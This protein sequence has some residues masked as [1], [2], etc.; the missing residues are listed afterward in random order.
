MFLIGLLISDS[1][2]QDEFD[3]IPNKET[4]IKIAEAIWLPMY[5]DKIYEN[6]P[7]KAVVENDSVWH[8]LGTLPKPSVKLN[9][10]GD[11]IIVFYQGG[12]PHIRLSRYTAEVLDVYHAK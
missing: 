8:V 1:F 4:A 9:D 2:G 12:V 11:S 10:K 7:F 5:G 6:K 3:S